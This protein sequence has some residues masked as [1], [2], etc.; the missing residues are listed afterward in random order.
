MWESFPD[1]RK[2]VNYHP[3]SWVMRLPLIGAGEEEPPYMFPEEGPEPQRGNLSSLAWILSSGPF[4]VISFHLGIFFGVKYMSEGVIRYRINVFLVVWQP[5]L[6]KPYLLL[7][8][9]KHPVTR[10]SAYPRVSLCLPSSGLS[11]S[12]LSLL[13]QFIN[14]CLFWHF[15]W[16]ELFRKVRYTGSSTYSFLS[17][18]LSTLCLFLSPWI[19]SVP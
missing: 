10:L 19:T 4:T 3:P 13:Q 9:E 17:L 11:C 14:Y 1:C 12:E 2:H 6:W 16:K 8:P 7:M 15:F 5:K 18:E